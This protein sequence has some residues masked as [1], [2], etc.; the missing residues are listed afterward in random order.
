MC[1]TLSVLSR[2]SSFEWRR[3][4][5]N[6]PGHEAGGRVAHG[7]GH[8]H[9]AWLLRRRQG[10]FL[11]FADFLAASRKCRDGASPPWSHRAHIP[12][13]LTRLIHTRRGGWRS[14]FLLY[15]PAISRLSHGYLTVI[16]RLSHGYL[17][18][19]SR[20]SQLYLAAIIRLSFGYPF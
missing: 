1:A 12:R 19:I 11:P 15:F 4:T 13:L 20:L 18:A 2:R 9:H 10:L 3:S 8:S 16:S 5:K 14:L 7:N 6:S 17:T